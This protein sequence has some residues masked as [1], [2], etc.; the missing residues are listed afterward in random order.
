MICS[1]SVELVEG[2]VDDM[3]ELGSSKYTV[4]FRPRPY[5]LDRGAVD[6]SR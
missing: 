3:E 1:I 6:E 4:R 5:L 2:I